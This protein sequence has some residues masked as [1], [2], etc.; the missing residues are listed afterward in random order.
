MNSMDRKQESPVRPFQGR[1][2]LDFHARASDRRSCLHKGFR[3]GQF[4]YSKPYWDGAQLTVQIVNPTAG[5][6]GNDRLYSRLTFHE[7]SRV[8]VFSP[9]SSQVYAM[10]GTAEAT[11]CQHLRIAG[12]A[13]A[14][15]LPKWTVLHKGACY[16]QTM[17]INRI[18]VNIA[19]Y[20]EN[21]DSTWA[22]QTSFLSQT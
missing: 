16:A 21:I 11:S 1:L 3:S 8:C 13:A 5:I 4:H 14:V 12:D 17:R 7:G 2:E 18:D 9:S 20:L 22:A 19:E 15:I 6:F 10:E